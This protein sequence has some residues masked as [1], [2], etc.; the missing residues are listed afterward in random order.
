MNTKPRQPNP[1]NKRKL[2]LEIIQQKRVNHSQMVVL[3][4]ENKRKTET[5]KISFN[6]LLNVIF[7]ALEL[8][9]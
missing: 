5:V 4:A 9:A 6:A 8:N 3:T 7:T 1:A 2:A